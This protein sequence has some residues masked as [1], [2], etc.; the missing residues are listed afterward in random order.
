MVA[1]P[2][3]GIALVVFAL[4]PISKRRRT[5]GTGEKETLVHQGGR[6]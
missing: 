4:R 3:I 5:P 6:T 1:F 2:L